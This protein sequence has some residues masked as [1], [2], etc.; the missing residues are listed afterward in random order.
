MF[1]SGLRGYQH[2]LV[3][4]RSVW[5]RKNSLVASIAVCSCFLPDLSLDFSRKRRGGVVGGGG[6]G[7]RRRR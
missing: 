4:V 7:G 5:M 2:H 6:G 3:G 1:A